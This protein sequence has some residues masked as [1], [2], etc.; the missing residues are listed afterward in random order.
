[1][2]TAVVKLSE[3]TS[4]LS[5]LEN[6]MTGCDSHRLHN[7]AAICSLPCFFQEPFRVALS[8]PLT[9]KIRMNDQLEDKLT[10]YCEVVKFLLGPYMTGNI[11]INA[12]AE[13]DCCQ[14]LTVMIADSYSAYPRRLWRVR[15]NTSCAYLS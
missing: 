4:L 7:G 14:Q 6:L 9:A 2:S 10:T 3:L 8:H 15:K 13:I 12:A 11:T 1:M 5:V